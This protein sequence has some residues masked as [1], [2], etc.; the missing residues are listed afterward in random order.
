MTVWL[1]GGP[2]A[3][4]TQQ[5][6]NGHNGPCTVLRDSKTTVPNPWSWNNVANMLYIDQPVQTGFSYD[7][8]VP[9]VLDMVTGQID[10]SGAAGLATNWTA[11]RGNFSSQNQSRTANTTAIAA[12]GVYHFLQLWFDE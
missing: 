3:G 10:V 7:E 6:V 1:Q 11:L 8:V 9:G 4:S 5:A 2:G 12:R